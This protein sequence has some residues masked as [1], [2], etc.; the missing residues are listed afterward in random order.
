MAFWAYYKRLSRYVK[1]LRYKIPN[2]IELYKERLREEIW[3]KMSPHDIERLSR[4]I[5]FMSR[6]PST[7]LD[8]TDIYAEEAFQE[9]FNNQPRDV[10][11]WIKEQCQA[12]EEARKRTLH[13]A[14]TSLSI[15]HA[16]TGNT[17]R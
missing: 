14:M 1:D 3:A 10:Q 7:Q 4:H 15:M 9:W 17:W 11:L 16:M 12:H 13:N 5:W 6:T 8:I 2:Q